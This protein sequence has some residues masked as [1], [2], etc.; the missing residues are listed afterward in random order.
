MRIPVHRWLTTYYPVPITHRTMK[1]RTCLIVLSFI[2][3][4]LVLLAW[5]LCRPEW[6]LINP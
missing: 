2:V 3:A 6:R 4:M 1:I 5:L